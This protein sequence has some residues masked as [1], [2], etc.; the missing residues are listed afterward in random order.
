MKILIIGGNSFFGKKLA[1]N[2]VAANHDITLLNRTNLD[3]DLGD[4]VQRIKCDRSDTTKM[5]E[6]LADTFWDVVY[7]QVCFDYDT[8]KAACEIF[9]NR[10]A[11]YIFTS[12]QSVYNA[13]KN[14]KEDDFNPGTHE[15]TQKE[16]AFSNYAEAKRQAEVGF[17]TL[18][19]FPASY[20]RFPIVLGD[21]D[22]TQRLLFHYNRI[23]EGKEIFFNSLDAKISF[24][25]SDD[26]AR[27]LMH[28]GENRILG[29]INCCN[30][31]GIS[32]GNFVNIIEDTVGKKLVLA[33]EKSDENYSP[34]AIDEDW[35]MSNE[36]LCESGFDITNIKSMVS[37]VVKSLL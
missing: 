12:S 2:L 35:F 25:S 19:A 34:Y 13:G 6:L 23:K 1:H 26:A 16:T 31:G 4:K 7:D 14:L 3:D 37:S 15:F 17:E 30:T 22:T 9:N 28:I 24:I 32:I 10:V 33:K 20:V 29:P 18:A 11:H 21:D 27:S 36:L 5:K 8:A